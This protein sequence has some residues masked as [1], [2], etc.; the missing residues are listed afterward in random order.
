[1][2][3]LG[4]CIGASTISV[5]ELESEVGDKNFN[6]GSPKIVSHC[7]YPHEGALR[8]KLITALNEV[9]MDLI[10]R[11]AVTGRKFREFINLTTIPEPEAVE[12]AVKCINPSHNNLSAVVSA[13]GETFMAYHL[14]KNGQVSNVATG[15]K[16]AS[17]TGEFFLQQLG[18]IDMT[19]DDVQNFSPDIKPYDVSGRCSVFCKSDCTHATN[20]GVER[21]S[22]VSGLCKMMAG[23]IIELLKRKEKKSVMVVGGTAQNHLMIKYLKNEIPGLIVPKEAPYFEALGAA[24]WAID[25]KTQS[26]PPYADIFN[27]Q[28]KSFARLSSLSKNSKLVEFKS[29][30][31]GTI[32]A[33]DECILGLDVGSTTTKAVLIRIADNAVLSSIYLRTNGDPVAASR[34]CYSEILSDIKRK[35]AF[36]DEIIISGIGATGS[37]RQIAGLHAF[38]D[39]VI[40]EIIAHATAATFFDPNVDTIFE[41]GGQD[42][43]YTYIVN[44]V[45]SDY[46]MNEACS[47]GTG[48]FLE[49]ACN[50]T[51]NVKMEEIADIAIRANSP[52][53][54]NDQCAAFISSDIKNAA[55]E[56]AKREEIISGLVYSI[57]MN[58]LNRV[59][60]NRPVGGKVFMQ[61]GVC[62]NKAVPL[63][64]ASL[65]GKSLVVPPEPGLMGAFLCQK[66]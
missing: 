41:I 28:K 44:S 4:I 18:R 29:M 40:N 19:L 30:K 5:V 61:G 52:L 54:F 11:V 34:K 20:K 35:G 46:A 48:S 60:G 56:G 65:L 45:P 57:C 6:N 14:N 2:R 27:S 1:M 53:N 22:V 55:H 15:N 62:Y 8:K 47:A 37:G 51:L 21:S 32:K 42:A 25:N 24:A 36:S 59:K 39:G 3:T 7:L 38:T 17:G 16:C 50:E 31:Q 58:Y 13:G 10:S 49:E 66:I 23:K 63:A 26:V 12:Y 64:M 33:G 43:K 9:D